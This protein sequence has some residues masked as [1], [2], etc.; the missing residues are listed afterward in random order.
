[1]VSGA[2]SS[3]FF[4]SVFLFENRPKTKQQQKKKKKRGGGGGQLFAG[5]VI[6]NGSAT[7]YGAMH[8]WVVKPQ[9]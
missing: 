7:Q 4:P 1:M 5:E 8:I 3:S 9:N 2:S 6:Q